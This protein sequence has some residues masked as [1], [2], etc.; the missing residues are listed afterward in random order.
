MPQPRKKPSKLSRIWSLM[1]APLV[2]LVLSGVGAGGTIIYSSLR[3]Q[4]EELQ[5]RRAEYIVLLAEYQH[6]VSTLID[7][8]SQLDPYIGEGLTFKGGKKIPDCGPLR[9]QWEKLSTKVG[10]RERDILRGQGDYVPTTPKFRGVDFLTLGAQIEQVGGVPDIQL[11]ALRLIRT[12]DWPP[13]ILWLNVR[14]YIPMMLK[15]GVAR[16]MLYTNGQLPLPRGTSLTRRQ[17]AALGFP[18]VKPGDLELRKAETMK[19]QAELDKALREGAT[20]ACPN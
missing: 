5:N 15:F 8:D 14:A 3:S 4:A 16:H 17:E 2:L 19:H 18:D 13:E 20:N 9:E 6:R 11:G 12:L 7:A 10:R 1:N